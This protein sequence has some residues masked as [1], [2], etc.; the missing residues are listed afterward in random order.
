MKSAGDIG[1]PIIFYQMLRIYVLPAAPPGIDHIAQS[2]TYQ[3]GGN[4]TT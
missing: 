1:I 2:D 3:R 4:P